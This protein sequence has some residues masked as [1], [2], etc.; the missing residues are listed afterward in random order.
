MR[1]RF[2]R[3]P[4]LVVGAL[5]A[6]VMVP[7]AR[8]QQ[9]KHEKYELPNGM[10]V[11]LHEDHTLPVAAV[12]IWY[13][14]GSK[15]EPK[16]RTGFA[17]LFEHLMFMGTRRVPG[18]EFD[19]IMETGGGANN[20]TTSSDR[21]NYFS[22]G[23]ASLLPTLLWLDADRLEDLARTMDQDKL[24][25]QRE[26]V[27]NEKKQSYENEPYGNL[28]LQIPELMYPEGHP[29]HI[30]VIGLDADINAATVG[31]VKDFFANF[32]V[33]NN[34]S[35]VV[36]G[37]FDSG[38]IK[39]L[40]A[41]LF[42][43]LPRGAEPARKTA[44]NVSPIAIDRVI[45]TT[46]ID[47]VALPMMALAYHSPAAYAPGDAEMDLLSAILTEGPSSRLY[48]RLIYDDQSAVSVSA[49]QD[50]SE[51]GSLMRITVMANPGADLDAIEK[52][53][54]EE[55][56][57]LLETW[58]TQEELDRARAPIELGMLSQL[59]SAEAKADLLN[60][61]EYAFGDPD[62][63]ERDLGRYRGATVETVRDSAR[64]VL[65]PN[66][67]LI[68]R[69]LPAE[70]EVAESARETRPSD[71][72][73][74][75]WAPPAPRAFE[76]ASGVPVMLWER[77]GTGIVAAQVV[78]A[79][80][81]PLDNS[82]SAGLSYLAMEMLDEGAGD[83]GALEFT[84]ALRK[85]GAELGIS[86]R[87]ESATVSLSVLKAN[88]DRGLGL[89]ADALL[90]PRMEEPEWDRVKRI[91]L[92]ELASQADQPAIVASRVALRS[93]FGDSSP[94]GWPL[95]GTPGSVEVL[96]A[97]DAKGR[98]AGLVD[99]AH[100]T[101]LLAG[102]ITEAEAKAILESRFGGWKRGA[103][104][105]S[106]PSPPAV[107]IRQASKP[108]GSASGSAAS[109]RIVVVDRPDAVQT[110]IRFIGPGP[111][112]ADAGRVNYRLLNTLL[113]GSF[114]SRL[115]QNLRERNGYTYGARSRFEMLPSMGYFTSGAA[116]RADATG[117]A[118]REFMAEFDRLRKG[119][120]SGAEAGKA[121]Q[122]VR[123]DVVQSFA[124]L[125][126]LLSVAGELV[127]NRVPFGTLASDLAA[128]DQ[129]S[130][131]ELNSLGGRV[132]NDLDGGVLVL[133][134]DKKL[135]T[136]QLAAEK[137]RGTIT[138][139]DAEGVPATK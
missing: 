23:P 85:A 84:D 16:G 105:P 1:C 46:V 12:N 41:G 108:A 19:V 59:Q 67:R 24:D 114:T 79:P 60:G 55:L 109:M 38:A 33:P 14:V 87:P 120:V 44:K 30:P 116:V 134:G 138:E 135:I 3:A 90:R 122:T 15:D 70:P 125:Q 58:V 82:R 53:V 74:G 133:V 68:A 39:P 73:T 111:K 132:M 61:Y 57:R 101:I 63:F 34:A 110:V 113:G 92:D 22:S 117:A 31:D 49:Y 88:A 123:T 17:H 76:L 4:A 94:M 99:P 8:A 35:L 77:P 27:L 7:L 36:A 11:I 43:T 32:Y 95:E 75:A 28:E 47:D 64:R 106:S 129:A 29:Y 21:T 18:N 124:G 86:T 72:Q 56:V 20:A 66:A 13:R 65:T 78:L 97:A 136:E 69:V 81:G 121:R 6:V 130:E 80:D 5:A 107:P 119:D 51:L 50:S 128:I 45:R 25:K 100:A 48:K 62:G 10:T 26:V 9:L 2:N 102:D 40:I 96:G 131:P 118:V 112:F 91:H 42:G 52:A 89:M 126:G 98:L 139:V 103:T 115:N 71:G 104:R 54:D 93:Y 137:I 83:L 127:A 37:D